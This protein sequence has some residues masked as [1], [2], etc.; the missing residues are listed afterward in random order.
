MDKKLF[1]DWCIETHNERLLEE[2]DREL[3]KGIDLDSLTAGSARYIWW[4]CK[5][6]HTWR[7]QICNRI[8]NGHVSECPYCINKKVWPGYNDIRT[9]SP[10]MAEMFDEEKNGIDA[11]HVLANS[12]QRYY[13]TCKNG[14][15]LR[16]MPKKFITHLTCWKCRVEAQRAERMSYMEKKPAAQPKEKKKPEPPQMLS[17]ANP[18][19]AREF[20]V[21]KNGIKASEVPYRR[22][23]HLKRWWKCPKGHSY[24][25]S[26]YHRKHGVRCPY[27]SKKNTKT[28]TGLNDLKTEHPELMPEWDFPKNE[29]IGLFPE[30]LRSG[31]MKTAFWKCPDCGAEWTCEIRTRSRGQMKCPRC[32]K[33]PKYG[34]KRVTK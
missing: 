18:K 22:D 14:H 30:K 33:R 4:R 34:R 23:V 27:C 29:A 19:L 26:M 32:F 12:T 31:S 5:E 24:Q 15:E 8:K 17:E 20:D 3:N 7:V 11:S 28:L 9:K 10:E 2:F 13:F 21:K 25:S 6:G 1:K 16:E